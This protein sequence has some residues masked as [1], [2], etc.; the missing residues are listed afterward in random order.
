MYRLPCPNQLV[1]VGMLTVPST[2][3]TV[4]SHQHVPPTMTEQP[5]AN[6]SADRAQDPVAHQQ[7]RHVL[8][9]MTEQPSGDDTADSA[10]HPVP[11]QTYQQVSPTSTTQRS[12]STFKSCLLTRV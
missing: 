2:L 12:G 9:T 6:D 1:L 11:I 10:Q 4:H 8:H 3:S 7:H 5:N